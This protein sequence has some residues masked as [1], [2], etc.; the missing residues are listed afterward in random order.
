MTA[1]LIAATGR[2]EA[3]VVDLQAA[4][5]QMLPGYGRVL[6]SDGPSTSDNLPGIWFTFTEF[7]PDDKHLGQQGHVLSML[8]APVK[9]FAI[10]KED[11]RDEFGEWIVNQ[12]LSRPCLTVS[13]NDGDIHHMEIYAEP[14]GLE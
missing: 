6:A 12:P 3:V 9:V 13:W 2:S 8:P 5:E 4:M 7:E 14:P 1:L 11:E 10:R